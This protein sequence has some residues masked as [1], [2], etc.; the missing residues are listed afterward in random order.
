MFEMEIVPCDTILFWIDRGVVVIK[1]GRY[2]FNIGYGF[3]V[4]GQ[5]LR[6][7]AIEGSGLS[8]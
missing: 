4:L 2:V 7:A 6:M 8:G 5:F 1:R 3:E